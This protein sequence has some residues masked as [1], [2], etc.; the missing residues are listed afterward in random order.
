[1]SNLIPV[2]RLWDQIETAIAA[3][4]G[5]PTVPRQP[6]AF[7]TKR[8]RLASELA[9]LKATPAGNP[10]QKRDKDTLTASL[11]QKLS[12]IDQM[13]PLAGRAVKLTIK[14][15]T[16]DVSEQALN[17]LFDRLMEV[18]STTN[19]GGNIEVTPP[20]SG[21]PFG[22]VVTGSVAGRDLQT[23]LTRLGNSQTLAQ[24]W[25]EV[26]TNWLN[27]GHIDEI[28]CFMAPVASGLGSPLVLRASP[29]VALALLDA[30]RK[31]QN[32]DVLVT[33]L[34]R[35]KKWRH[36]EDRSILDPLYP[37]G[38]YR[39]LVNQY[40]KYNLSDFR[41]PTSSYPLGP[42]AYYDDR[43]YLFYLAGNAAARQYAAHMSVQEALDICRDTNQT[44]DDVLLAGKGKSAKQSD[45][46]LLAG[47]PPDTFTELLN[48]GLDVVAA[49]SFPGATLIPLPVLFDRVDLFATSSTEAVTPD[50][51]NLQQLGR[52][53]LV[54][55]PYGPRLRPSAA[56][57]LLSPLVDDNKV[58]GL[59][60]SIRKALLKVLTVAN[61]QSRRLDV[62]THWTSPDESCLRWEPASLNNR[63]YKDAVDDID[64]VAEL[65]RD[66]FDEFINPD[67]DYTAGDTPLM[68]PTRDHFTTNIRLVRE[69]ILKA[70]P[71]AYSAQGYVNGNAWVRI[72]IPEN[73][74]DL[75]EVYT[76]LLLEVL[77]YT[78]KWVDSWFYHVH[79][80]GV[81][82]ATNVLRNIAPKAFTQRAAAA[83]K[84]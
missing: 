63:G 11:D 2:T 77:G 72:V 21:A 5:K 51:V 7:F 55:K 64:V 68:Q 60:D 37:P 59:P 81:H 61:L 70:N 12:S 9:L 31:A 26:N 30:A 25:V 34:F 69:R 1:L 18:H 57:A 44:I 43:K 48:S 58:F 79:S 15:Q 76:Q 13:V 17:D 49:K 22:T 39:F 78:V 82:C 40:G 20:S 16:V 56:I 54:P 36:E 29:K 33:R 66:G 47:L 83:Q 84:L 32:S 14:S 23:L 27:V 24:P 8:E 3:L 75:F 52:T 4:K 10:E 80:G 53:L 74:V 46:P 6:L 73:T 38:T 19:Y 71:N 45:Y 62:T 50:L 65:F 41:T 67:R 42:S 35:G 28:A